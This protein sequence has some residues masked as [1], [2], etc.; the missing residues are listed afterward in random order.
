MFIPPTL[1]ATAAVSAVG[2]LSSL[3]DAASSSASTAVAK[4][5]SDLGK[6]DFL[7]LLVAQL[8]NQDP[9]DPMDST[10]FASQLAQ[11]SSLEQLMQINEKIS[12]ALDEAGSSSVVDAVSFLGREVSF[13]GDEIS[14]AAGKADGIDFTLG[15]KSSVTL[16]ITDSS[17]GRVASIDLGEKAAGAQHL[18]LATLDDLPDLADGTY[19]VKLTAKAS[20]GVS[21]DLATS[22]RGTVTGVDLSADPPVLLVGEQRVALESIDEVRA[23]SSA[24]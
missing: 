19:T 8:E 10:Q 13:A 2:A 21:Q 1:A 15:G 4:S 14:V 7:T 6:Q 20:T 18:D 9:L 22:I 11:Y 17:G 5:G 12:D 23:A 3:A 24:S 16:E